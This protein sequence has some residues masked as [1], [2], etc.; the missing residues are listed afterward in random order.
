[1]N[2]QK[3]GISSPS[4]MQGGVGKN[5]SFKKNAKRGAEEGEFGSGDGEGPCVEPK[6]SCLSEP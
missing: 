6:G 4:L 1:V 2:P 3:K 5:V